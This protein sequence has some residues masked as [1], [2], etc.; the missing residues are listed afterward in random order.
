HEP[1]RQRS[2]HRASQAGSDYLPATGATW[3]QSGTDALKFSNI[4]AGLFSQS[5]MWNIQPPNRSVAVN[6]TSG[7]LRVDGKSWSDGAF[8]NPGWFGA[9]NFAL[10]GRKYS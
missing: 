6:G 2:A 1:L 7:R 4:P 10:N 8:V 3:R 5:Q 9:G